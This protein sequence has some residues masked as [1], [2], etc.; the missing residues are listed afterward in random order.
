VGFDIVHLNLHKS[1]GQPDSGGCGFHGPL[2][3][4]TRN[5]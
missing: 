3:T 2:G 1:F 5:D 4:C